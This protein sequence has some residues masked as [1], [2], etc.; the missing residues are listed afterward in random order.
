MIWRPQRRVLEWASDSDEQ[1]RRSVHSPSETGKLHSKPHLLFLSH[2]VPN[3]PNKGEKIR[4]HY[5]ISRLAREYRIHLACFA[6]TEAEMQDALDL[7]DLCASMRIEL[8]PYRTALLRALGRFAL[9]ECLNTSFYHSPGLRAYVEWRRATPLSGIFVYS[10]P[11]AQY[12]PKDAPLL[13]DMVDVDSEKWLEYGRLRWPG[14][15]YS[16]EGRRLREVERQVAARANCTIVAT[17]QEEALLQTFSPHRVMTLENGVNF[18]YFDPAAAQRIESLRGREFLVFVGAM[19]YYPNV[20]AVRRFAIEIFSRL[21]RHNPGL[22]LLIVGHNPS[23]AVRALARIGG[24]TVTG[25]VSDVRPY[26]AAARA[27]VAPLRI[28]RGIQNKVL[29]ALAMGKPVFAASAVCRTFGPELPR[30]VVCCDSA[31]DYHNALASPDADDI[32]RAARIRFGWST[33]LNQ[34][35]S[36]LRA[37]IDA[38][39]GSLSSFACK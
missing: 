21:R 2:C 33:N 10:S 26:L 28:A 5:E 30:G 29:E 34:L 38:Y 27:V 19:S 35:T 9:G 11:M 37:I 15:A 1:T 18:E 4:A 8:L 13:L 32:R 14:P 39:D 17:R 3:P 31:E 24:V 36:E 25:S 23:Q 12:A 16:L 20:D 22:E 7:R 6:R